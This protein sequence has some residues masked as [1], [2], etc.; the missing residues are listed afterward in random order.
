WISYDTIKDKV[1]CDT[2]CSANK[3]QLTLPAT[4]RDCKSYSAF[5]KEGFSNWKKAIERF[6]THEKSNLH[7]A[8]VCSLGV[9][10]AGVNVAAACSEAKQKQMKEARSALI[11]ILSSLQYL[12]CQGLSVRGHTDE[13]SNLNQLLALLAENIPELKSWLNRTKYRWMSHDI[14]NEMIEIMAHDIL[15]TL[16]K[17]IHEAGFFSI[18]MDETADISVR[19]QVSVCLRIVNKDLDTEERFFGFYNT[20]S[21]T[22]QALYTLLKDVLCR[23][24]CYDGAAN[25]AG[26]RRGLQALVQED[27]PRAVYVHCLTHTVNLVVQDVAQNIA[28]CRNFLTLIRELISLAKSSPKRLAWFKEFQRADKETLRSFCPTRW[29]LRAALLQ[30]VASNYSELLEFLEELS[31]HDKSDAGDLQKFDTY[32][33][34]E[35]VNTALQSH[36]LHFHQAELKI[37]TLKENISQ[38]REGFTEFWSKTTKTAE[39]LDLESPSILR[40]RKVPRHFDDGALP[41][42]F[43]SPEEL[44]RQ[45][46]YEVIDC[47]TNSLCNRFTSSVFTHMTEIEK[48]VIGK[49]DCENISN[50][51]KNDI[52]KGKLQLHRDMFLDIAKQRSIHLST[53]Q[54]VVDVFSG[55]KGKHLRELLPELTK[56][57]KLVLTVPVASC[58]S[59]RS[60]SSLRRIKTYLRSTMGQA[61]LNHV[62]ILHDHKHLARKINLNMVANEFIRQSA[63]RRNTFH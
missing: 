31:V 11:N 54:D 48:F 10:K 8:A 1:F 3:I 38:L 55:E 62:A 46:Y 9:V 52:D 17:E 56:L 51:Y 16:M 20:S 61:R 47:V 35:T 33:T 15:R 37:K 5:V 24:Q 45:K 41:H 30:S 49:G 42:T 25:V 36:T 23:G 19:E 21:T 22:S 13:E 63:S 12:S 57:I 39:R 59:G 18:I 26:C 27:E 2:C 6:G 29:T 43:Q 34:A 28:A 44:Y 14:V 60:F 50:F 32:F 53:L 58:T 40:P 4:S 7:R